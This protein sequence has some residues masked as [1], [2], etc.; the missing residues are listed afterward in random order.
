MDAGL[1]EIT[2][3]DYS[4]IILEQIRNFNARFNLLLVELG[5]QTCNLQFELLDSG[6]EFCNW[7]S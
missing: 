4:A 6:G 2:V 1:L 7:I 5:L 3:G